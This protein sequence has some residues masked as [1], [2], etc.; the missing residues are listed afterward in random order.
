MQFLSEA[1]HM[2]VG[3]KLLNGRKVYFSPNVMGKFFLYRQ[4][5]RKLKE[6]GG[7]IIGRYLLENN[8]QVIDKITEPIKRDK[9]SIFSFFRSNKHNHYLKKAWEKSDKTQTLMGTW[10]THPESDP[11]PSNKDFEDWKNILNK[12]DYIGNSLIFVIVGIDKIRIW[13]NN[14]YNM[15]TEITE[16]NKGG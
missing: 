1:K 9:R 6:A 12:G 11:K 7:L 14:N 4:I 15:F 2:K 8:H 5:N 13:E 10:H 16:I 3:Y